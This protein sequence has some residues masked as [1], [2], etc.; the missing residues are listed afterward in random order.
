MEGDS[1]SCR[2]EKRS[3][4]NQDR[5]ARSSSHTN[6]SYHRVDAGGPSRAA[7]RARGGGQGSSTTASSHQAPSNV[8]GDPIVDADEEPL[9]RAGSTIAVPVQQPP[10]S[11]PQHPIHE[12]AAFDAPTP[13]VREPALAPNHGGW[14]PP[15]PVNYRHN[16]REIRSHR[17]RNL[18]AEDE[19]DLHLEYCFY[20]PFHYDYYDSILHRKFFRK[21]NPPVVQMKCITKY[22]LKMS[23]KEQD[24]QQMVIDLRNMDLISLM[25]FWKHWNNEIIL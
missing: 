21:G 17:S 5:V 22:S 20:H 4:L 1:P 2:S 14:A 12:L 24:L 25:E 19:K 13:H 11:G 10:Y 9:E 15:R 6:T 3:K 8:G 18:Y 23:F 16:V 7:V